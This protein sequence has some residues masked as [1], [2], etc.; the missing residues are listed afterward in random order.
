[1][2]SRMSAHSDPSDTNSDDGS[3]TLSH[4]RCVDTITSTHF[5]TS[6]GTTIYS[7]ASNKTASVA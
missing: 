3:H 4:R 5:P 1:M 7:V 6:S 2:H